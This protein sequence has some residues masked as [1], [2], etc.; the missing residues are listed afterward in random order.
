M[1]H[2][3]IHANNMRKQVHLLSPDAPQSNI[4]H[5]FIYIYII[6]I[7]VGNFG[8]LWMTTCILWLPALN[9]L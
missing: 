3:F 7:N 4:L 5:Y 1:I 6:E 2:R 8:F 9:L